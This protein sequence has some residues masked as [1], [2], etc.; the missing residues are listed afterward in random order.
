MK[1]SA[2]LLGLLLV[3]A[4]FTPQGLAQPDPA[5][6]PIACC[7][8]VVKRKISIQRLKSYRITS[9]DCSQEAVIFK[10]KLG[11]EVCADPMEKWVQDSMKCLDQKSQTL[12]P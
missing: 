10:T 7:F 6:I 2:A 9:I 3:A 1:V 8:S 11:R 12:K 5:S 4:I